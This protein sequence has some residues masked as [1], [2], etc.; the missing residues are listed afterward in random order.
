M[1]SNSGY[2]KEKGRISVQFLKSTK[3]FSQHYT[4]WGK[5]E[6]GLFFSKLMHEYNIY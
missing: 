1:I 6:I 5:S 2:L 3:N 4:K